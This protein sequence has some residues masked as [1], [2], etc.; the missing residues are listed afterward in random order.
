MCF[1]NTNFSFLKEIVTINADQEEILKEAAGHLQSHLIDIIPTQPMSK[2]LTCSELPTN[3]PEVVAEEFQ[4]TAE[5]SEIVSAEPVFESQLEMEIEN[6]QSEEEEL[7][8]EAPVLLQHEELTADAEQTLTEDKELIK[9]VEMII[10]DEEE[11]LVTNG[12]ESDSVELNCEGIL[13]ID[14]TDGFVKDLVEDEQQVDE[15]KE[16]LL[17][18]EEIAAIVQEMLQITEDQVLGITHGQSGKETMRQGNEK[19]ESEVSEEHALKNFTDTSDAM[20]APE[21]LS[22]SAVVFEDEMTA[23]DEESWVIIEEL[24][25]R[26]E[27]VEEELPTSPSKVNEKRDDLAKSPKLL[28]HLRFACIEAFEDSSYKPVCVDVCGNKSTI[29]ITIE[30]C[31]IDQDESGNDAVHTHEIGENDVHCSTVSENVV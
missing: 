4:P 20:E 6:L 7:P 18:A 8:V 27:A 2:G 22:E 25:S 17:V 1:I 12:L 11:Q 13:V 9:M 5:V 14:S 23:V 15:S 29:H 24:P 21:M 31:P 10:S 28:S 19:E 16:P 3:V 30:V 26:L